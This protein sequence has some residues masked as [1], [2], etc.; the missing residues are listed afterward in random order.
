V[1][2]GLGEG[3][4]VSIKARRGPIPDQ[5]SGIGEE[6]GGIGEETGDGRPPRRAGSRSSRSR[7]GGPRASGA[8]WGDGRAQRRRTRR[9][10]VA[11]TGTG[12][13]GRGELTAVVTSRG[14]VG[15]GTLKPALIPC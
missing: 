10:A 4:R 7:V 1:G 2:G 8:S 12:D 5:T 11:R 3:V 9:T 15:A 6:M 13:G 14:S